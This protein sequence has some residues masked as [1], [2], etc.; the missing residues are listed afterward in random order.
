LKY[1][2][3]VMFGVLTCE[4][5][6]QAIARTLDDVKGVEPSILSKLKGLAPVGNKGREAGEAVLETLYGIHQLSVASHE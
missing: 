3:P 1:G 4:N 6:A 5:E 2:K